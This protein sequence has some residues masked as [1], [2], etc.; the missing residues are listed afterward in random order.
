MR[1]IIVALLVTILLLGG[2]TPENKPENKD[3]P[4]GVQN[5]I[6][7]GV[8]GSIGYYHDKERGVG[9]W[10]TPSGIFVL[11]DSEYHTPID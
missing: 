5:L 9:I 2:C 10:V 4:N 7:T 8:A 3:N 1:K 6:N 11:P